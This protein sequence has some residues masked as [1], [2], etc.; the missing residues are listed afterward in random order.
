[1]D[2]D[3]ANII[4]SETNKLK[5]WTKEATGIRRRSS[6]TINRDEGACT[7]LHTW[8]SILQRPSKAGEAA[9]K[10]TRQQQLDEA[11]EGDWGDSRNCQAGN[12]FTIRLICLNKRKA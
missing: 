7:F 2:W 4:A 8:D 1:M 11:S 12:I 10:M 9:V 3:K 6:G 5:R